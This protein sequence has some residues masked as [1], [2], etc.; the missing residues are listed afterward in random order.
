M[1]NQVKQAVKGFIITF[2][3]AVII[4]SLLP[5]VWGIDCYYVN[6]FYN[7]GSDIYCARFTFLSGLDSLH[8]V[9]AYAIVVLSV[10]SLVLIIT[11]FEKIELCLSGVRAVFMIIYAIMAMTTSASIYEFGIA[12]ICVTIASF[13]LSLGWFLYSKYKLSH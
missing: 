5:M 8:L 3:L 2:N 9:L 6:P 11:N 4:M 7:N 10:A 13:L 12:H 1:T